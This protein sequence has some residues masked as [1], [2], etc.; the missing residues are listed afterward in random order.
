MVAKAEAKTKAPFPHSEQ[1]L[2]EDEEEKEDNDMEELNAGILE[3]E[4]LNLEPSA[5][6][7]FPPDPILQVSKNNED[8][9]YKEWQG[10]V[11]R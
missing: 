8:G 9:P 4:N 3:Q 6:R 5:W 10:F 1:L 7:D 2:D 11:K